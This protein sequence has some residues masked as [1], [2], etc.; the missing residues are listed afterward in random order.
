VPRA[1]VPPVESHP[2][3]AA[4]QAA[5]DS[6]LRKN[7]PEIAELLADRLAERI[8]ARTPQ[9]S[10]DPQDQVDALKHLTLE[11]TWTTLGV[12]RSTLLRMIDAGKF[13]QPTKLSKNRV[14]ISVTALRKWQK[15]QE[16][17]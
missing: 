1:C 11:E 13:P 7:L 3:D 8:A 12:S 5:V 9:Q 17:R 2:F 15:E 10:H 14:G 4:I 16:A 6:A